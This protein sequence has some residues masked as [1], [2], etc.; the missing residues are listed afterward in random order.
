MPQFRTPIEGAPG[1]LDEQLTR[2][3]RLLGS[4]DLVEVAAGGTREVLR[5]EGDR[6][7]VVHDMLVVPGLPDTEYTPRGLAVGLK[8]GA[9]LLFDTDRLGWLAAWRGGFLFRTKSGR[10]WEWH[11]E[12]APLWKA[13]ARRPPVVLVEADGTVRNPTE[14]RERFGSFRS[15][16]FV[17]EGVRI[18]YR[19]GFAD[20]PPVDVTEEIRPIDGG[21]DRSVRIAS[22]PAGLVPAIVEQPPAESGRSTP[23]GWTVGTDRVTLTWDR[24]STPLVWPPVA[25]DGLLLRMGREDGGGFAGRVSVRVTAVR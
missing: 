11:P 15:L 1:T 10:L 16:E 22:A 8:N 17:G 9:S 23:V 20:V 25:T 5:R 21:W 19:L 24:A 3:W 18:A 12:G 13:A 14:V 6:A 2:I 7:L 4:D